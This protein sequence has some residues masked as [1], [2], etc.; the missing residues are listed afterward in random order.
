[1]WF[2][3]R[4]RRRRHRRRPRHIYLEH[5]VLVKIRCQ[6]ILEKPEG[7]NLS[8]ALCDVSGALKGLICAVVL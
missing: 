3:L 7:F 5:L 6:V 2:Q 8:S 1:M 4:R